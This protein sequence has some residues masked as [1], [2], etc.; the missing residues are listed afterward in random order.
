MLSAI[1]GAKEGAFHFLLVERQGAFVINETFIYK[2]DPAIILYMKHMVEHPQLP[3]PSP[4]IQTPTYFL[5]LVSTLL[6]ILGSE[7]AFRTRVMPMSDLRR[8]EEAS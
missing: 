7:L 6:L 2:N 4:E 5:K 1:F 3:K 8:R